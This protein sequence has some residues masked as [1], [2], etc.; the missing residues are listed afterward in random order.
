MPKVTSDRYRV[1]IQ[2]PSGVRYKALAHSVEEDE[3]LFVVC[4]SRPRPRHIAS[5]VMNPMG[6]QMSDSAHPVH[7]HDLHYHPS[8]EIRIKDEAG[9]LIRTV[10]SRP[11]PMLAEPTQLFF[12]SAAQF[13]QFDEDKKKLELGDQVIVWGGVEGR[14]IHAE[15]WV[16]PK[17]AFGPQFQW[18]HGWASRLV[19]ED[20]ALYDVCHIVG[21]GPVIDESIKSG[22]IPIAHTVLTGTVNFE[23][24]PE[25]AP[26]R[27]AEQWSTP[28]A[29]GRQVRALMEG[30]HEQ[31]LAALGWPVG[32]SWLLK[33]SVCKEGAVAGLD[34]QGPGNRNGYT[35]DDCLMLSR[36]DVMRILMG[37]RSGFV[38]LA[39]VDP[40]SVGGERGAVFVRVDDTKPSPHLHNAIVLVADQHLDRRYWR[41]R[42]GAFGNPSGLLDVIAR[43]R[44]SD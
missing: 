39:D 38:D 37:D 6:L 10:Q 34:T 17:G 30:R 31:L 21:E 43:L 42:P 24:P 15:T 12:H 14:R 5:L 16:G 26:D 2:A 40:P 41:I 11:L 4:R 9:K 28:H 35:S 22:D 33:I 27:P 36:E 20:A 32:T 44:S 29:M 25:N 23:A 7:A 1:S 18:P 13:S 19:Y 8:G 3:S